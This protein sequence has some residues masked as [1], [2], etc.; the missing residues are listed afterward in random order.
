MKRHLI[1]LLA[2]SLYWL[3]SSYAQDSSQDVEKACQFQGYS[4]QKIRDREAQIVKAIRDSDN[5]LMVNLIDYPLT[6]FLPTGK[7]IVNNP[8]EFLKFQSQIITASDAELVMNKLTKNPDNVICRANGVGILGGG[9]WLTPYSLKIKSVNSIAIP[10]TKLT[11]NEP[12]GNPVPAISDKN[13]LNEFANIYNNYYH[14]S[15]ADGPALFVIRITQY[16]YQLDS[17]ENEGN[18]ELYYADINN[19]GTPEY[20]LSYDD[21]GSMGTD[22]IRFVGQMKNGTLIPM[23]LNKLIF[24]NFHIKLDKWYLFH[25]SPFLTE[26][27]SIYMNY[28]NND[29]KCTYLWKGDKITLINQDSSHCLTPK[30]QQQHSTN[31]P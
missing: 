27:G 28:T 22:G 14:L 2:L 16:G 1:P 12:Y 8:Q 10:N 20:V 4:L 29:V 15:P 21:Q 17:E 6:I 25:G 11:P 7:R 5:K 30:A 13:K 31:S 9:I 26:H 19:D 18:I 3:P 24:N 23:N